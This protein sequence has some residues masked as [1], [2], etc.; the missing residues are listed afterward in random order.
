MHIGLYG[1]TFDPPHWGH[2]KLAEWVYQFLNLEYIYFIP[3]ALHAFK[4][5]QNMSPA[6]RRYDMVLAA[7][8]AHPHFRI[9]RIEIDRPGTSYTIDTLT[10]FVAF[11]HLAQ[12]ELFYI[13]GS[14]NLTD[15]GRWKN[16]DQILELATL[17]VLR[18]AGSAGTGEIFPEHKNIVYAESPVIDISATE[19]REK[20]KNRQ[21]ISSLVPP[22]VSTIIQKYHLYQSD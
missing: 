17:V 1:G 10:N 13:I 5:K 15:F 19:I 2:L 11:E 18:R 14:D 20:V 9:S 4:G 8:R 12:A 7:I 6:E 3:A 21:D 22:A 16:P